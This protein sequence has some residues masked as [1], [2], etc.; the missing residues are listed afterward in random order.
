MGFNYEV[1]PDNMVH[2]YTHRVESMGALAFG[3]GEW[4]THAKRDPWNVFTF[5]EMDHPGAPSQVG[6]CHVP[7]NGLSG[8]DY[9]NQRRVLSWAD[10]WYTY[11]DLRGNP[12]LVSSFEWS[13]NHLGYQRWILEHIPKSPGFTAYGYNNWW[14]YIANTDEE[15]PEWKGPDPSSFRLPD[16][17]PAPGPK[18]A[19]K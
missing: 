2:S 5:L 10:Q 17:M 4:D 7:P 11:P 8:Y 6:N 9:N 18:P 1:G 16:S 13:N 12:R 19:L 14:V 15:L 3:D